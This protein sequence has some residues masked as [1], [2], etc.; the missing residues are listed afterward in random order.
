MKKML[1]LQDIFCL[2]QVH[3]VHKELIRNITASLNKLYS[4]YIKQRVY[5]EGAL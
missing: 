1:T 2:S 4:K 3:A 5:N